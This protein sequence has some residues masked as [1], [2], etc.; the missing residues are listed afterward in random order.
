MFILTFVLSF[1]YT[2]SILDV[3]YHVKS[4]F[5]FY[6]STIIYFTTQVSYVYLN[7]CYICYACHHNFYS[8]SILQTK[9]QNIS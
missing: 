2:L 3:S 5:Y 1:K 4:F 7:I 9:V 8:K 6:Q